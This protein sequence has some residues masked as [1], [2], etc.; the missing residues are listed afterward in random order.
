VHLL[1]PSRTGISL[2]LSQVYLRTVVHL[3]ARCKD[4]STLL[5][6]RVQLRS[7]MSINL[8]ICDLSRLCRRSR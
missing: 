5:T 8:C 7:E 2:V 1:L 4:P 6:S 3:I